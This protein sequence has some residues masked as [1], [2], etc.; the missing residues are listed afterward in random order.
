MSEIEIELNPDGEP[1]KRFTDAEIARYDG[2]DVSSISFSHQLAV[3]SVLT[4]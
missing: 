3:F 2:R 1:A 4:V